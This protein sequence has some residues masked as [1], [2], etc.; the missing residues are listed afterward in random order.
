MNIDTAII[1]HYSRLSLRNAGL[2]KSRANEMAGLADWRADERI[3][4]TMKRK[5]NKP[6]PALRRLSVNVAKRCLQRP[7]QLWM[8]RSQSGTEGSRSCQLECGALEGR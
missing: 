4:Y 2:G 1:S 6:G 5:H 8:T 3:T 7:Q